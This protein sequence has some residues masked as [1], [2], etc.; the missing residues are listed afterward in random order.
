MVLFDNFSYND[1]I[2][3]LDILIKFPNLL[4]NNLTLANIEVFESKIL[5]QL[6]LNYAISK[7]KVEVESIE[8]KNNNE[9]DSENDNNTKKTNKSAVVANN[10]DIIELK[11]LFLIT[12][13]I[14]NACINNI[15]TSQLFNQSIIANMTSR[16]NEIPKEVWLIKFKIIHTY[17]Y[18]LINYLEFYGILKHFYKLQA[19]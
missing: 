19:K 6:N 17:I 2:G 16:V 14:N 1:L 4:E 18:N 8:R 10:I 5:S 11:K 7:V 15:K 3:L 12:N 13:E 9:N